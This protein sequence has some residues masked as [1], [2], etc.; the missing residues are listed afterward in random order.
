VQGLGIGGSRLV[1]V[2][3]RHESTSTA[4]TVIEVFSNPKKKILFTRRKSSFLKK[5]TKKLCRGFGGFGSFLEDAFRLQCRE[6]L[7]TATLMN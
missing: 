1:S 7:A 3:Y 2:L 6:L 4:E 5:R